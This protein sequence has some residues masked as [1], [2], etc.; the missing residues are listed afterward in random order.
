VPEAASPDIIL[1]VIAVWLTNFT[2]CCQIRTRLLILCKS[3]CVGTLQLVNILWWIHNLPRVWLSVSCDRFWVF[4]PHFEDAMSMS[5]W[6][7]RECVFKNGNLIGW[8]SKNEPQPI[9]AHV[10]SV[11]GTRK[12]TNGNSPGI[13]SWPKTA[14]VAIG[15]AFY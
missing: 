7:V 9:T 4:F 13:W 8:R 6:T 12:P 3:S 11:H 14:V 5:P 1:R 15:A 2:V 10:V